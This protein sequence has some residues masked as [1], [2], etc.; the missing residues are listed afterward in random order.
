MQD[1]V[2]W[3]QGI[4]GSMAAVNGIAPMRPCPNNADFCSV[5]STKDGTVPPGT[6]QLCDRIICDD[7][8][9]KLQVHARVFFFRQCRLF[10]FELSLL[11][12]ASA[13]NYGATQQPFFLAVGFRRP[14]LPFRHPAPWDD[15]YPDPDSIPLAQYPRMDVSTPPIAFHEVTIGGYQ[16]SPSQPIPNATAALLRRDYYACI[17]WVDFN[18]GR[19]L[20][21]IDA[22]G[23]GN[24]TVVAFHADHGWSLGEAG[25]WEKFT[26]WEHGTRVPLIVRAPWITSSVGRVVQVCEVQKHVKHLFGLS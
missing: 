26:N 4:N 8:I 22:L 18:V 11:I 14:H 5:N 6:F 12:Q 7:A 13:K 2:S 16:A 1:P 9:A 17:S 20:D 15:V 19:I 25:E 10:E 3:T 21:E 23:L 24:D